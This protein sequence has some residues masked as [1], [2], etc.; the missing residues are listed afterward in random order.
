MTGAE[1][2]ALLGSNLSTDSGAKTR[3]GS[4][5]KLDPNNR[6]KNINWDWHQQR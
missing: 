6:F 1:D 3:L 4:R 5:T 2:K